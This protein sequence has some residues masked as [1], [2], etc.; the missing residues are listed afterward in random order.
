MRDFVTFSI[1]G[2]DYATRVDQ[3]REVVRLAELVAL[4]GMQAPFAGVLD[5]RGRSLPVIDVRPPGGE[6]TGDVLV[7]GGQGDELGF[8]CDRVMEVVDADSLTP[9]EGAVSSGTGL[10]TYV[11]QVLRGSGGPVFLVDVRA[12]AGNPELPQT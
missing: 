1:G 8:V 9:E 4:P 12:M 7:L 11:E 10:P 6:G 2:H 5:L 3:V